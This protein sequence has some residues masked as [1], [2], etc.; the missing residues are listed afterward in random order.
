VTLRSLLLPLACLLPAV[1]EL[2]AQSVDHAALQRLLVAEDARG[3]GPDSLQP[4]LRGLESQDTLLV[5]VAARGLGRLQ[6]ADAG[7]RLLP[8]LTNPLPAIRAEAA[9]AIAQSLR[10]MP[11]G[12][13][14]AQPSD[15]SVAQ[16]LSALT[17]LIRQER[18]D[19]VA[20]V[21]A[22]AIGRLQLV[23]SVQGR[24][25]EQAIIDRAGRQVNY[26]MAHGLFWLA[27]AR[28]FSGGLS[29]PSIALLNAAA[30]SSADTGTRRMAVLTLARAG[31]LDSV[32]TLATYRDADAQVRRL[33][34]GGAGTLSPST[35]AELV[36]RAFQDSS[37]IVRVAAVAAARAGANPPDCSPLITALEDPHPYV[38][39]AALDAMGSPCR[40][41]DEVAE[42]LARVTG[43]GEAN[44]ETAPRSW[45]ANAHALVALARVDSAAALPFVEQFSTSR[46][47]QKRLYA[48]T[49]AGHL[50]HTTTLHQ[51]AR[52]RDDNVREAAI[53]ALAAVSKH[54]ADT[55]YLAALSAEGNQVLLAAS[56]ALE[57]TAHTRALPVILDAF[58]RISRRR[59]ENAR[60]PRLSMLKRIGELGTAAIA[61]RLRPYLTDF[62]TTVARNTA[63]ILSRWTGT[64]VESSP[65][66]LPIRE[67][68]LAEF[69]LADNLRL[70]VTMARSSGGG[71][72]VIHLFPRE[73]PA[74]VARVVRRAREKYYDGHLFQRVEPNFVI[75]GG[76]PGASEY[77]GDDV[78]MRDEV[79]F[80]SHYR[81]TLGISTRGRD[82]GDAQVFIN[83]VDNPALDHEFTVFGQVIEGM[84]VVDQILESDEIGRVE[85]LTSGR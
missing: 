40:N 11:R 30:L 38:I 73:T 80:H 76:G 85:V 50:K 51:L 70:R 18:N 75:Q 55:M 52:D 20:G 72:F 2:A 71:T 81:G 1:S 64:P 82:T 36:R 56:E 28:R 44:T 54:S 43:F 42:I 69:F 27:L 22:E 83:L 31:A 60:D 23:D 29:A 79:G 74:T 57:G 39:L 45:Q 63:A 46:L 77:V 33:A 47:W 25:A 68:P 48:A 14:Q 41:R 34:L 84:E 49:A 12:A 6:R 13:A 10:G 32:T 61:D 8:L 59:S 62:D 37:V 3:T 53:A 7:A 15:L 5:R 78:F 21:I 24:A 26:G 65:A 4:L 17:A 66:P 16:V 67:E 58:D 9:I 35:R 19:S